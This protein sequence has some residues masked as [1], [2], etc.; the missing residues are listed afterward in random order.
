M[1][2]LFL[3]EPT[4]ARKTQEKVR[5]IVAVLVD[6][7]GS[8]S[9]KDE[10]MGPGPKLAETIALGLLPAK[11]RPLKT[12]AMEQAAS[13][14]GVVNTAKEGSPVANALAT[15]GGMSRYERAI[16]LTQN[17]VVPQL[18][19]E[20]RLKLFAMD[21]GLV[22]LELTQPAKLIPN[23]ATDFEASQAALGRM[24]A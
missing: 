9:V 19:D 15:L 10:L 21:T 2:I 7:S 20:T 5:P 17:Q 12:N 4:L 14:K 8:T 23:R 11:A 22:L 16:Q 6:Q 24:W 13:D 1:L 18:Q 3:L